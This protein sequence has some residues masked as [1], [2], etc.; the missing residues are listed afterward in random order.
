[1]RQ[2]R[3]FH[4]L[5]LNSRNVETNLKTAN[6][7]LLSIEGIVKHKLLPFRDHHA[8]LTITFA[9]ADTKYNI[10]G[11][12]FS[13]TIVKHLILNIRV[14]FRNSAYILQLLSDKYRFY[15]V[16][17]QPTFYS[18]VFGLTVKKQNNI[19]GP[20]LR[21]VKFSLKKVLVFSTKQTLKTDVLSF[22]LLKQ[23][24]NHLNATETYDSG[25]QAQYLNVLLENITKDPI[26]IPGIL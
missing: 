17:K 6:C 5:N 1:M 16:F 13:E 21:V 23:L 25:T 22:Q 14:L 8:T 9:K 2:K 7:Q 11:L 26:A 3:T 4:Y 24:Y 20:H 19:P 18:K 15:K 10:L 12:P